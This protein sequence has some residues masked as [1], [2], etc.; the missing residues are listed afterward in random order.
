MRHKIEYTVSVGG[1]IVD[2]GV[3]Y[4]VPGKSQVIDRNAP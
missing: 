1:E 3:K 2:K 4:A